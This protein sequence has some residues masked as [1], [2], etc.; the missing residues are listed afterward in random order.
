MSTPVTGSVDNLLVIDSLGGERLA[1][2][3][4]PGDGWRNFVMYRAAARADN[5][6]VTFALT[7]VGEAWIDNVSIQTIR[8]GLPLP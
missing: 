2:R 4:V 5:V 8:R 1:E 6:T 7:G 3:I